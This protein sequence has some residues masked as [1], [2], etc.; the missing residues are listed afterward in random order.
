[1]NTYYSATL[2]QRVYQVLSLYFLIV[3]LVLYIK[4]GDYSDYFHLVEEE[5]KAQR[6]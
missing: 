6:A 1:M 5:S 3:F 4:A 2:S